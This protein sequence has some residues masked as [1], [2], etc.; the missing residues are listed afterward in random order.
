MDLT[1]LY[2][3]SYG[4]YVVCSKNGD[5]L[6]GQIANTVMQV[7][8]EPPKILVCINKENLTYQYINESGIFAV[9]V[10]DQDTPMKFIGHFGFKSGREFDK[11][12][13]MDYKTGK[14]GAPIITS[15]TL[16]YLE[17]EVAVS[18][19]V[20]THTTFVGKVIDAQILK[21]GEPLTYAFYH[22]I[23]KGKSPEKA[24]TYIP[25]NIKENKEKEEKEMDK[26]L[27]K[28]CGYVYDPEKG[29]PDNG[30]EPGTPFE[31]LP[32]DWVCPI[33][34]ADKGMFEKEE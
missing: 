7:T 19:D 6:N 5:K 8:A 13:E 9:S 10:L 24:P 27:C 17:C 15:N 25:A 14:T 11:F 33:C 3:I 34:G 31:K 2:K 4:M 32:G 28:V 23:K 16:G 18:M 1:T 21:E 22:Q 30:I 26:Y 29:D 12:K 20:G